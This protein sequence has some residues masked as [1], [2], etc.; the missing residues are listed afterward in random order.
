[1]ARLLKE[2]EGV[3]KYYQAGSL[4]VVWICFDV[5]HVAVSLEIK[6]IIILSKLKVHVKNLFQQ[7]EVRI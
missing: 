6:V 7:L 3:H 1:M 5:I 2:P 4:V